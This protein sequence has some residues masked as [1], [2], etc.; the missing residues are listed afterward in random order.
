MLTISIQVVFPGHGVVDD[1]AQESF[2]VGFLDS[3][4]SNFNLNDLVFVF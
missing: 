1:Q 4:S 3:V 2:T